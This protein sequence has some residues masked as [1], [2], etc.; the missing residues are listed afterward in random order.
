MRTLVKFALLVAVAGICLCL[1]AAQPAASA[2]ANGT[3]AIT[4]SPSLT[5]TTVP[6]IAGIAAAP[7][8]A[9]IP[10]TVPSTP[11][12]TTPRPSV[13]AA[14]SAT[15]AVPLTTDRQTA[16][17]TIVGTAE[18]SPTPAS[19]TASNPT[20]LPPAGSSNATP[21]SIPAEFRT[22]DIDPGMTPYTGATEIQTAEETATPE[23]P[24]GAMTVVTTGPPVTASNF[25]AE[26]VQS[27]PFELPPG[28]Y[29][30]SLTP[31]PSPTTTE[32]PAALLGPRGA[33]GAP[34]VSR[35]AMFLAFILVGIAGVAGLALVGARVGAGG[36]LWRAVAPV[37]AQSAT[38]T[39]RGMHLLQAE[40]PDPTIGEEILLDQIEG[41]EPGSMHVERLGQTILGFEREIQARLKDP[42]MRIGRILNL[43]AIPS[44]PVPAAAALWSRVHGFRILAID[45]SGMALVMPV[46]SDGGRTVLGV[47]PAAE[48]VEGANPVPM[49]VLPADVT[50]RSPSRGSGSA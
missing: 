10:N 13:T 41:F 17:P 40:A 27:P 26:V 9:T 3:R 29:R 28:A 23:A 2:P 44:V 33:A 25:T 15:T 4:P 1:S 46:L 35:W 48:M 47:V 42:S 34:V 22:P 39:V 6:T 32:V 24:V 50:R 19:T 18:E 12:A 5:Q 8:S 45:G 16:A 49:P 36:R 7:P 20:A 30:I 14:T 38:S 31:S 37:T 11:E 43:S 21:F